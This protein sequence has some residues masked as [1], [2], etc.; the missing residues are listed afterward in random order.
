MQKSSNALQFGVS[1][2]G[3]V[4]LSGSHRSGVVSEF[5]PKTSV[6]R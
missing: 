3:E 4:I 2:L 6:P 1:R 5:E